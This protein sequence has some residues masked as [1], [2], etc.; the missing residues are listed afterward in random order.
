MT[1]AEKVL[2]HLRD[3]GSIT[4]LTAMSD[5]GIMRLGARIYDLR[6]LGHPIISEHERGTN[7]YGEP[8]HWARYTLVKGAE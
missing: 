1:Q 5:Y 6:Q 3:Y 7:R 4:P 8:T 2:R